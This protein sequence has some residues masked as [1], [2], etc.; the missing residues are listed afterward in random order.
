[1]TYH[2]KDSPTLAESPRPGK[3]QVQDHLEANRLEMTC[4]TSSSSRPQTRPITSHL[5]RLTEPTHQLSIILQFSWNDVNRPYR[6]P[7]LQLY[8]TLATSYSIVQHVEI[9]SNRK[10]ICGTKTRKLCWNKGSWGK[11]QQHSNLN[12]NK[13]IIFSV[14]IE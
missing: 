8:L 6:F 11:K 7:N 10:P 13:L 12:P 9:W 2:L 3:F 5:P 14:E 1:M 4:R